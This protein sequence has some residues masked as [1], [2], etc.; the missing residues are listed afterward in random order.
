[1]KVRKRD[2]S[3]QSFDIDKIKLTLERVSD[4]LNMPFTGSD[5]RILTKVIE[6]EVLKTSKEVIDSGEIHKIV[7]DTL[8]KFNFKQIAEAYDHFK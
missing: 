5:L 4:S 2:G 8:V 7:V 3:L 6:E 1:M